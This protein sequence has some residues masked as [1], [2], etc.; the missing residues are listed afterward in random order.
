MRLAF[1]IITA[2]VLLAA[3][4]SA[5]PV[6]AQ[7]LDLSTLQGVFDGIGSS[8]NANS[9]EKAQ[10]ET[11]NFQSTG[12]TATYVATA[13]FAGA[14]EFGLYDNYD[15]SNQ[16]TLFDTTWSSSNSPGR[17]TMVL[18]T[19]NVTQSNWSAI[20]PPEDAST[21]RPKAMNEVSSAYW[22]AV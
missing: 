11:F 3:P 8:I 4:A 14:I 17:A 21:V 16:L 7:S 5:G 6:D 2:A 13:S 1:S 12:S 20:Q 10:G 9:D 18:M 22:V 19:K 15:S